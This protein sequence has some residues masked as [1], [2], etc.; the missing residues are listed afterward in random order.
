MYDFAYHKPTS[1]A[2]AVKLLADPDAKAVS[3]G[4]T[5]IPALKHRLNK[6]TALVDLSGIAEMKGI[7][8]EGN[9]IIIGALTRHVEVANSAEVKA[10]I[11]A[12]AYLASH[13]GDVQVRNRGTIGGSVSNNDPAA[14]YPAAVLGLGAT[15]HTNKR[16]IAADDFFQGMFTT[17]LEADEILERLL[18]PMVNEGARILEEGIASRPIDIDVIFTNGFGWPAWRGGPMFWADTLGLKAVRD[19]LNKYAEATG[20]KNLRPTALIEKLADE[21]G[22]FAAMGKSKV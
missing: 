4:H 3:G 6:P 8:R 21:G 7:R 2:D 22:S 10:A 9:A 13:I 17:A 11:P 18:L 16:K 14:D 15:I 5:L 12:L 19:K 20:D 1:L